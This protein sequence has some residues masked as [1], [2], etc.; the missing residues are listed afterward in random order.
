MVVHRTRGVTASQGSPDTYLL[1]I[2]HVGTRAGSHDVIFY[3]ICFD[4][5]LDSLIGLQN[6]VS[7]DPSG[8]RVLNPPFSPPEMTLARRAV[9]LCRVC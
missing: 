7:L 4:K 2:N 5:D 6:E 3:G 8:R 1:K 9:I